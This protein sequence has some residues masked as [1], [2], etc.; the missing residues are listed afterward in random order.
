MIDWRT[1][2]DRLLLL[3]LVEE[4]STP[5]MNLFLERMRMAL[6]KED[7]RNS[8]RERDDQSM[9]QEIQE[10]GSFFPDQDMW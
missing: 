5:E 7:F 2:G 10:K 6:T 3:L 9:E 1:G 8:E 4:G